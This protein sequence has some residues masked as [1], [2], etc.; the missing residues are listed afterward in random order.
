[1]NY[2]DSPIVLDGIGEKKLNFLHNMGI[3]KNID[4]LF[5]FPFRYDDWTTLDN[6]DRVDLTSEM[7]YFGE[8]VSIKEYDTYRGKKYLKANITSNQGNMSVLWFNQGW[9]KQ[10]LKIGRKYIFFGKLT[11]RLPKNLIV[12][13]FYKISNETDLQNLLCIQPVYLG[14]KQLSSEVL[15]KFIDQV[16]T[17]LIENPLFEILSSST[18]EKYDLTSFNKAMLNLHRPQNIT[19]IN[20]AKRS[21]IIY[22]WLIF[23]SCLDLNQKDSVSGFPLNGKDDLFWEIVKKLPFSLT[24]A[25]KKSN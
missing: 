6:I 5:H 24:N 22:E 15:R 10:S 23:L 13:D 18:R 12:R 16:L 1:M 14:T 25:Q 20:K 2:F 21:M 17:Y 7:V 3:K 4:F 8:L 9:L 19:S 11:S